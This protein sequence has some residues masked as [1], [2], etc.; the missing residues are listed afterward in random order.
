MTRRRW[1]IGVVALAASIVLPETLS[2]QHT[3]ASK[4]MSPSS[5]KPKRVK[6]AVLPVLCRVE[7]WKPALA[8]LVSSTVV[9][10]MRG[11]KLTKS[12]QNWAFEVDSVV[13]P[14]E[15]GRIGLLMGISDFDRIP[16]SNRVVL[17]EALKADWLLKVEVCSAK[18]IRSDTRATS[19]VGLKFRLYEPIEG[20]LV[21]G[22][23]EIGSSS[24]EQPNRGLPD[25]MGPAVSH[26]VL[27]ALNRIV[28]QSRNEGHIIA[29]GHGDALTVLI[30]RGLRDGYDSG[31]D[32]EVLRDGKRRG[33]LR[34]LQAFPTDSE[35]LVTRIGDG[36]R[37]G[38]TVRHKFKMPEFAREES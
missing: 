38:D 1:I 33:S 22:A 29:A 10:S 34:I 7:R 26:A 11:I 36:M 4:P 13:E 8:R 15:V 12:G 24:S 23:A 25:S 35:A 21:N 30:N 5:S 14:D 32:L 37:P 6:I 28:R 2:G 16:A 17:A 31:D 18:V 19:E 3:G 27:L 20:V 9:R